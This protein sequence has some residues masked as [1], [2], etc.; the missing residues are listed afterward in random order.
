M[1]FTALLAV[2]VCSFL[3]LT[4]AAPNPIPVVTVVLDQP[5]QLINYSDNATDVAFTGSVKVDKLP[6]ERMW[7]VL[8]ASVDKGWN[9]NC[10]PSTIVITDTNAHEFT[11]T[12]TVPGKVPDNSGN[13]S[14]EASGAAGFTQTARCNGSIVITG[15]P[16]P[17][18][19]VTNQTKTNTT[20]GGSNGDQTGAGGSSAAPKNDIVS[21][22]ARN[23]VLVSATVL[24]VILV[25][26]IAAFARSRRK[27]A[28]EV[29][30]VVEDEP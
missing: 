30:E 19:N 12:V 26:A 1:R 13:L 15:R 28:V 14:V 7:V 16:P 9:T 25:V 22:L 8:A 4:Q 18:V 23:A 2:A 10:T 11:C 20:G 5:M 6:M 24:V 21:Q 29:V 17:P 3:P 27:G